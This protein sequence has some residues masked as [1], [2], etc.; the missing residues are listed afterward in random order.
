MFIVL[1]EDGRAEAKRLREWNKEVKTDFLYYVHFA[2]FLK[3]VMIF[4]KLMWTM[5][6]RWTYTSIN[7]LK[8][9]AYC[10]ERNCSL[11]SRD[12]CIMGLRRN[13]D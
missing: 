12:L 3:S 5:Q 4:G 13:S 7:R 2:G 11:Y 9:S 6:K 1:H 8:R 10:T